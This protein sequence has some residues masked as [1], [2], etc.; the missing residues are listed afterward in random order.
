M[1]VCLLL[2]TCDLYAACGFP[3]LSVSL[4]PCVFLS[5]DSYCWEA[6]R[7]S[8]NQEIAALYG[9]WTVFTIYG[10]EK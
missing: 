8:A 5:A 4:Y 6:N 10:T 3:S 7:F 9:T 1:S 2:A